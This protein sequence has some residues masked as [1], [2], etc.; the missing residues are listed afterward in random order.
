MNLVLLL[1]LGQ[2]GR[3]GT[4]EYFCHFAKVNT[5]VVR[6]RPGTFRKPLGVLLMEKWSVLLLPTLRY[7]NYEAGLFHNFMGKMQK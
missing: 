6:S 1:V 3:L 5:L 4:T 7:P 2:L